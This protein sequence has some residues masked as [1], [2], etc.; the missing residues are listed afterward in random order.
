MILNIFIKISRK[1][2]I[3]IRKYLGFHTVLVESKQAQLRKCLEGGGGDVC[4]KNRNVIMC[5][6]GEPFVFKGS[7]REK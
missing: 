4:S 7:V 3:Y 1:I 6:E 5:T 2:W